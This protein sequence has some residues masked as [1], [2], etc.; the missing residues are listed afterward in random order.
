MTDLELI[1]TMLGEAS[2]TEIARNTESARV[3]EP[4]KAADNPYEA[5]I[6]DAACKADHSELLKKEVNR[7]RSEV[8]EI[9]YDNCMLRVD[10]IPRCGE[11]IN[12]LF[13][14]QQ[15]RDKA[16]PSFLEYLKEHDDLKNDIR[17]LSAER[18]DL[19]RKSK[20]SLSGEYRHSAIQKACKSGN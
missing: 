17:R 3:G 12:Q 19:M 15:D 7:K 18:C 1:F 16:G 5:C 6:K 20:N 4:G 10:N 11:V 2:T 14:A 9:S 13:H 8:N